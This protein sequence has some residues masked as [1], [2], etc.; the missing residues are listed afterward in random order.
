MRLDE[1][2]LVFILITLMLVGAACTPLIT[3][4]LFRTGEPFLALALLGEEGMAEH[5][6]PQ[7]DPNIAVGDVV[8]WTLYLYNHVGEAQYVAVRVKLLN[9]SMLAP[10]ATSCTPSPALVV[11]EARRVVVDNETWLYP[12]SWSIGRV[13]QDG[14]FTKITRLRVNEGDFETDVIAIGGYNYRLIF[15]LL[16][17]DEDLKALQFGWSS[18]DELYCAWNQVWF[19]ATSRR[20]S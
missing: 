19:N 1:W 20:V 12:V 11:Y 13:E 6:Y 18:G 9:A 5:Y 4:Y 3:S 7:N 17:F 15:E 10:N 14:A 2:H 8:Q 16:V